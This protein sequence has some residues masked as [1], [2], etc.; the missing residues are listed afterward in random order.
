MDGQP[1]GSGQ[2]QADPGHARGTSARPALGSVLGAEATGGARRASKRGVARAQ[3]RGRGPVAGAGAGTGRWPAAVWG[4]RECWLP[5]VM[6]IRSVAGCLISNH[7]SM[8]L[9]PTREA[10]PPFFIAGS[11]FPKE[12]WKQVAV[13]QQHKAIAHPRGARP[14]DIR[15]GLPSV[16]LTALKPS[17]RTTGPE[18]RERCPAVQGASPWKASRAPTAWPSVLPLAPEVTTVPGDRTGSPAPCRPPRGRRDARPAA[19]GAGAGRR[20][21]RGQGRRPRPS[22]GR[23]PRVPASPTVRHD[24]CSGWRMSPD[25]R[26]VPLGLCFCKSLA[27]S[28]V[29]GWKARFCCGLKFVSL[30]WEMPLV[31]RISQF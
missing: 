7:G 11:R 10:L 15:E 13:S 19:A 20:G 29:C 18:A 3:G 30:I 23:R 1:A 26:K 24:P 22:E 14:K 12:S 21:E 8:V 2:R 9:R 4:R 17:H 6:S 28:S 16:V 5:P 25:S 27:S 31:A